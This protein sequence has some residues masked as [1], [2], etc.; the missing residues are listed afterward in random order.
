MNII[1]LLKIQKEPQKVGL[2]VIRFLDFLKQNPIATKC[3]YC[4]HIWSLN[5]ATGNID[6]HLS[7]YHQQ[8][9]F[10]LCSNTN[11]TP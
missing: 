7:N 8:K 5:T 4:D 2:I 10:P 11:V 6:A 1:N 9:M 3:N